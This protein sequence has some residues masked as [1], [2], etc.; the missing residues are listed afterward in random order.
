VSTEYSVL[1]PLV[2]RPDDHPPASVGSGALFISRDTKTNSAQI[3][4]DSTGAI[5]VAYAAFNRA[6]D[7]TQP[8]F[9]AF[10][11]TSCAGQASWATVALSD[12][13]QEV[14]LALDPQGRPRMLIRMTDANLDTFYQYAACDARCTR[15][16]G[17]Q[18][19]AVTPTRNLDTSLFDYSQHSFAL[20]PQG[21]PR[22]VYYDELNAPHNGT[23]YRFCDAGCTS[24]ANWRE[25]RLNDNLL[26]DASIAYTAS[27]Q[28]RFAAVSY[29]GPE[30][31]LTYFA[32]DAGCD[33]PANWREQ[34]LYERGSGRAGFVLRLDGAGRPRVAFYQ[35]ATDDG[36]G[37]KLFYLWCDEN[38]ASGGRWERAGVG[39]AAQQGQEPDLA[40]DA[41]NRPRIVYRQAQPQGL[42]YG[43]C[44]SACETTGAVWQ[45]RL[46]E[47]SVAL[48][49]DWPI[50][51]PDGC[52]MAFWY[53]GYRPSLA[54]D[55]ADSPRIAY[56]AEHAHGGGNCAQPRVDYKAVRVLLAQ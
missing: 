40:L 19:V 14:Q 46:A 31:M 8:A 36:Q 33:S 38:C 50:A 53:G 51:P 30:S 1:L 23:F 25:I 10:C 35:G 45:H 2:V 29:G 42:G 55:P 13:V 20:D 56:D 3:Q 5:H 21:R 44:A 48:D 15:A 52:T 41:Q 37:Q 39:L 49:V 54:L 16:G 11:S 9:Y 28:P 26:A 6:P 4:V 32:C 17:W 24:A 7:G 18:L 27:G 43:S 34:A 12:R 22:F 47:G